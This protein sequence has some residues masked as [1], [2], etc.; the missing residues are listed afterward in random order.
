MKIS[1]LVYAIIVMALISFAGRVLADELGICEIF[2]HSSS[3]VAANAL[4]EFKRMPEAEKAYLAKNASKVYGAFF[5]N[6]RNVDIQK[7]LLK[8]IGSKSYTPSVERDLS[9]YTRLRSEVS[10]TE[11]DYCLLVKALAPYLP[12]T[13]DFSKYYALFPEQGVASYQPQ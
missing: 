7:Q 3:L 8:G 6:I 4:D 13:A 10:F 12:R 5:R 1:P 11:K 2:P 9:L